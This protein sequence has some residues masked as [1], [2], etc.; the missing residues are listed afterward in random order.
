MRFAFA[1]RKLAGRFPPALASFCFPRGGGKPLWLLMPWLG[2][3]IPWLI[4][5]QP[6]KV[7][8][9]YGFLHISSIHYNRLAISNFPIS[10]LPAARCPIG[11]A[12][13]RGVGTELELMIG[14]ATNHPSTVNHPGTT[15]SHIHQVSIKSPSSLHQLSINHL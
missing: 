3:F 2:W 12:G 14:D 8:D 1:H 10:A 4:R 7:L 13:G 5:F 9:F 6:S 11:V 15:R